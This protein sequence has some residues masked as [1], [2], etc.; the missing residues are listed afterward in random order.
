MTIDVSQKLRNDILESLLFTKERTIVLNPELV[1]MGNCFQGEDKDNSQLDTNFLRTADILPFR[2][3]QVGEFGAIGDICALSYSDDL[4]RDLGTRKVIYHVRDQHGCF[5]GTSQVVAVTIPLPHLRDIGILDP[6]SGSYL[7][8][9]VYSDREHFSQLA[10]S[11]LPVA[12]RELEES[13]VTDEE[14]RLSNL[15]ELLFP[16]KWL[17]HPTKHRFQG[18]ILLTDREGARK[19]H[20]F[21]LYSPSFLHEVL[22]R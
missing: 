22:S 17:T 3:L 12:L 7:G 1:T 6:M 4:V 13:I 9:M 16:T 10:K 18:H 19:Y 20:T 11:L 5:E 14:S 2:Y 8:A 21:S 15:R